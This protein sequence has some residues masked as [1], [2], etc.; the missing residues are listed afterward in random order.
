[1]RAPSFRQFKRFT[2]PSRRRY[3]GHGHV[4][5][6]GRTPICDRGSGGMRGGCGTTCEAFREEAPYVFATSPPS[7]MMQASEFWVRSLLSPNVTQ[8][9]PSARKP[10]EE[11]MKAHVM[12]VSDASGSPNPMD[13]TANELKK[14]N[15]KLKKEV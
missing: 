6:H 2:V 4:C 11:G 3:R 12:Q 7:Q 14:A 10:A 1:M 9:T 13:D 15:K 8:L 5:S